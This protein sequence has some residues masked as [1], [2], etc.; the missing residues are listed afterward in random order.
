MLVTL[1]KEVDARTLARMK[2]EADEVDHDHDGVQ[3]KHDN[4][5][6]KWIRVAKFARQAAVAINKADILRLTR[7]GVVSAIAWCKSSNNAQVIM[8]PKTNLRV[9]VVWLILATK[10]ARPSKE[11]AAVR[12]AITLTR[13]VLPR[14]MGKLWFATEAA[15]KEVTPSTVENGLLRSSTVVRWWSGTVDNDIVYNWSRFVLRN[16]ALR[17]ATLKNKSLQKQNYRPMLLQREPQFELVDLPSS[18]SSSFACW[19]PLQ[20]SLADQRMDRVAFV[21]VSV[22]LASRGPKNNEV[23]L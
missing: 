1:S 16:R 10:F 2:N 5:E 22:E 23:L 7:A 9:N 14:V 17:S 12:I 20:E 6:Y 8:N 19:D 21:L 3:H 13:P 4:G 15:V 18:A 11:H